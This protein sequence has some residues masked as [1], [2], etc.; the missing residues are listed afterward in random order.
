MVGFFVKTTKKISE[1]AKLLKRDNGIDKDLE[2]G[3]RE[4]INPEEEIV[5]SQSHTDFKPDK[6]YH[7][8]RELMFMRLKER[9]KEHPL[10]KMTGMEKVSQRKSRRRPLRSRNE[11]N[12]ETSLKV[13]SSPFQDGHD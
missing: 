7:K 13:Q 11:R 3:V 9:Q 12:K 8:Q 6:N 1:L 10:T 4:E 2:S 5:I